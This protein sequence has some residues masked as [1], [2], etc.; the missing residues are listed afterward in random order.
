M[1]DFEFLASGSH[2]NFIERSRQPLNSTELE[3]KD[4][5]ESIF[6][7]GIDTLRR[8]RTKAFSQEGA[9]QQ[10]TLLEARKLSTFM[11]TNILE[12]VSKDRPEPIHPNISKYILESQKKL[13][14]YEPG[15]AHHIPPPNSVRNL[16]KATE[17]MM[18]RIEVKVG[19]PQKPSR[20]LT[21]DETLEVLSQFLTG[22]NFLSYNATD[23]LFD[24]NT[25]V[26]GITSGGLVYLEIARLAAEKYAGLKINTFAIMS[27][28]ET[29]SAI[30]ESVS[31]DRNITCVIVTDDMV[32]RGGT[33]LT[34]LSKVGKY[35]PN[36]KVYSEKAT[37]EPGY[38]Q[39]KENESHNSHL[40]LLFQDFAQL[41]IDRDFSGADKILLQAKNYAK[42]NNVELTPG[43]T[44][45]QGKNQEERKK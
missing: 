9:A 4:Q 43:W 10:Q 16:F 11:A 44:I 31:S 34:A 2:T 39:K 25:K 13:L 20:K 17:D 12:A 18:A 29:K 14:G 41:S 19:S 8:L 5:N 26:G 21:R 22:T 15:S 33:L 32:D 42:E 35:F 40:T 45:R 7:P 27:D 1:F 6:R 23:R 36:A 30:C 38:Y 3:A 37:L 24:K 28:K